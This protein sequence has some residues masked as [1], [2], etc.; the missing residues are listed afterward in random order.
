MFDFQQTCLLTNDKLG[1][2]FLEYNFHFYRDCDEWEETEGK[3]LC[4]SLHRHWTYTVASSVYI[5][6]LSQDI[7]NS[8]LSAHPYLATGHMQ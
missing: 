4:I 1:I 7:Y 5:L 3:L 2:D 6:T 8:T